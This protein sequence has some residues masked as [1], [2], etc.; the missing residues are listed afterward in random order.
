MKAKRHLEIVWETHEITTI[1]FNQNR[2]VTF[3][4]RTCQSDTPHLSAAAAAALLH[5]TAR[6]I[7]R[8]AECGQ[9]H[10]TETDEDL[11]MLCGN[12]LAA[13]EEN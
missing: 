7:F 13:L 3:F 1:S 4:C 12:S 2:R 11:L 8:L 5:T 6:E 10:S 9:I